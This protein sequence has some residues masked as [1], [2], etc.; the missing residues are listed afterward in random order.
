MSAAF[1]TP[2]PAD[3]AAAPALDSGSCLADQPG[4]CVDGQVAQSLRIGAVFI[5]L[6]CSSIG[7]WLPYVMGEACF[8][9]ALMR[10]D[11]FERNPIVFTK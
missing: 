2:S 8:M 10:V 7:V 1:L 6:A 5:V 9:I 4:D 3:A 11:S